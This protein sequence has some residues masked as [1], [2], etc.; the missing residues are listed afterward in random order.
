[1]DVFKTRYFSYCRLQLLLIGQWPYQTKLT[2]VPI[3]ICVTFLTT[4]FI[5]AEIRHIIKSR[6]QIQPLLEAI[7]YLL[8]CA[9]ISVKYLTIWINSGTVKKVMNRIQYDWHNATLNNEDHIL[10]ANAEQGWRCCRLYLLTMYLLSSGVFIL[11]FIPE[12]LNMPISRNIARFLQPARGEFLIDQDKYYAV[13]LSYLIVVFIYAVISCTAMT[14]QWI[15]I[16]NHACGMFAI[17][18]YRLEHVFRASSRKRA[19]NDSVKEILV[20]TVEYHNEI[21]KYVATVNST[22]TF[23][24]IPLLI[25][26]CAILSTL[27]VQAYIDIENSICYQ[28][29]GLLTIQYAACLF[30]TYV[31]AVTAQKLID[32]SSKVFRQI[33]YGEWYNASISDQKTLL[34]IMQNCMEPASIT[35]ANFLTISMEKFGTVIKVSISCFTMLY[36][37]S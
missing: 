27:L 33:Y 32:A 29:I 6:H 5:S 20:H 16:I 3:Q 13:I 36:S 18:G 22:Y 31:D 11:Q 10:K 30:Y 7:P 28:E 14:V 8:L 25:I 24:Y 19:R 23:Y 2:A 21:I 15:M 17:F 1:M 37:L 35:T 9:A 34:L 4:A 12:I 26:G